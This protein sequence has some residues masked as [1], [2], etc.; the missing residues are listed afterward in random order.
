MLRTRRMREIRT[1]GGNVKLPAI[2]FARQVKEA[3]SAR[4]LIYGPKANSV[5]GTKS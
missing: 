4:N 5:T 1:Y 3:E 2:T